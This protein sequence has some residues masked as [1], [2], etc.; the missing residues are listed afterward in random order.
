MVKDRAAPPKYLLHVT[1]H[2]EKDRYT[3]IEQSE[4]L[5]LKIYIY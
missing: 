2:T 4:H 1:T 3:L 5:M